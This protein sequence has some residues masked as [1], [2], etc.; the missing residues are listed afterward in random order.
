[1]DAAE[2]VTQLQL[3]EFIEPLLMLQ[4]AEKLESLIWR[5]YGWHESL[6]EPNSMVNYKLNMIISY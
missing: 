2:I 3:E 1:M 5:V 4:K 6:Q